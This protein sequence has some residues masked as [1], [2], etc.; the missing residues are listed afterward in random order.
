MMVVCHV[1]SPRAPWWRVLEQ[2][3]SAEGEPGEVL[4]MVEEEEE[5]VV[6]VGGELVIDPK[7]K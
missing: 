5:H 2:M 4:D 7:S 6:Y 3:M 1:C